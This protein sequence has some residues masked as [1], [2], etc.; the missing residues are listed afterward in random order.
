MGTIVYLTL[1]F[2]LYYKSLDP[3]MGCGR[4][5]WSHSLGDLALGRGM[6]ELFSEISQV[7]AAPFCSQWVTMWCFT[8]QGA[9]TT[10]TLITT[11]VSVLRPFRKVNEKGVLLWDKIY[12]LQKGQIY[13]QV[14]HDQF[15][16]LTAL[17]CM[18]SNDDSS[19]R[20][21]RGWQCSVVCPVDC[22]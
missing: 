16:P 13:K 8:Q 22:L 18:V 6:S 10:T 17:L 3:G 5:G 12:K 1:G 20:P 19:P 14:P 4:W 7:R 2:F 11:P 15:I 9:C 21:T